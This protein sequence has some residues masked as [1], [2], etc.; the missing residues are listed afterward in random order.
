M[1]A[2]EKLQVMLPGAASEMITLLYEDAASD[3]LSWTNRDIV[4]PSLEPVVRQ[5]VILRY[6]KVGIEGET[7]H[8]E[9]GISRSF[10]D[11]PSDLQQSIGQHRLLKAVGRRATQ[12][13]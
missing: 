11:L 12:R 10:A 4:T 5:L 9:G 1:T 13:A 3:I 7:N 8:S 6:N 2:E